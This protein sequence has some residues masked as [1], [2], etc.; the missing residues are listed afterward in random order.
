V[1]ARHIGTFDISIEEYCDI[2][3]FLI[4]KH[5]ET[6]GKRTTVAQ[7]EARL[8]ISTLASPVRTLMFDGGRGNGKTG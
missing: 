7:L 5:P 3:S 8:P 6:H 4:A 2:C 1:L